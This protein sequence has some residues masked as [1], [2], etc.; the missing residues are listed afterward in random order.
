MVPQRVFEEGHLDVHFNWVSWE[1][2]NEMMTLVTIAVAIAPKKDKM[3]RDVRRTKWTTVAGRYILNLSDVMGTYAHPIL[4]STLPSILICFAGLTASMA[5]PPQAQPLTSTAQSKASLLPSSYWLPN[6]CP[7]GLLGK[8]NSRA[9][10]PSDTTEPDMWC[11][12]ESFPTGKV[13][14]SNRR[15]L[16]ICLLRLFCGIDRFVSCG[17]TSGPPLA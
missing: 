8:V 17:S 13:G 15:P 11:N 12:Q 3:I 14:W 9:V 5:D 7:L 16:L 2:R 1:M 10:H 6:R 4:S